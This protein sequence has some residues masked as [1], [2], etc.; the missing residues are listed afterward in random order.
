VPESPPACTDT[1]PSRSG[2][3]FERYSIR[4]RSVP[5]TYPAEYRTD[6]ACCLCTARNNSTVVCC[7]QHT[8]NTHPDKPS[9]LK[10]NAIRTVPGFLLCRA[11]QL[12]AIADRNTRPHYSTARSCS[13]LLTASCATRQGT[14]HHGSHID[15]R[16]RPDLAMEVWRGTHAHSPLA[17][18][19]AGAGSLRSQCPMLPQAHSD[20]D[21][22]D[23][24]QLTARPG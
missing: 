3:S 22:L 14:K 9:S 11:E 4:G 8:V 2:M 12:S 19:A 6:G 10:P 24:T 7:C 16:Q 20:P 5:C 18:Q 1:L 15:H 17:C 23:H 21:P 13:L